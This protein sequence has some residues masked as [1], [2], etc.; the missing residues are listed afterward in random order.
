[1]GV[2]ASNAVCHVEAFDLRGSGNQ[3]RSTYVTHP[4][5]IEDG[6]D[7]PKMFAGLVLVVRGDRS[8]QAHL[9]FIID[10]QSLLNDE[11]ETVPSNQG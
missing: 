5:F 8:E 4:Q 6:S 10:P 11:C 9:K 3:G 7:S 2:H 1:M